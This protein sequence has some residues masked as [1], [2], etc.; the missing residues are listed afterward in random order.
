[1]KLNKV[2][3]A[4]CGVTG[5]VAALLGVVNYVS[6]PAIT[7]GCIDALKAKAD[8]DQ[9]KMILP[10]QDGGFFLLLQGE[11]PNNVKFYGFL[12]PKSA[13]NLKGLMLENGLQKVSVHLDGQCET[14]GGLL[15]TLVSGQYDVPEP[16]PDPI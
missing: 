15:Y 13:A 9:N 10:N 8:T 1:M 4:V 12:G 14:D 16:K 7:V 3:L 6:K 11:R 2:L 5:A